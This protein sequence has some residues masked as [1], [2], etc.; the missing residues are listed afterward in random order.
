[1]RT[2]YISLMLYT[3]NLRY[4]RPSSAKFYLG[5]FP[6]ANNSIFVFT[7]IIIGTTTQPQ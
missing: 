4:R 1:M 2:E 5:Q 7:I 6:C 3:F